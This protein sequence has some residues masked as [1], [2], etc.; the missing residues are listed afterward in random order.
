MLVGLRN[1]SEPLKEGSVGDDEEYANFCRKIDIQPQDQRE[2][3][4]IV[5]QLPPSDLELT[6]MLVGLRNISEPTQRG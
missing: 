3:T 6:G 5:D 1:I 4:R 2:E